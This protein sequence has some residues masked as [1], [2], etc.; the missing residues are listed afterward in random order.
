MV[1]V[2]RMRCSSRSLNFVIGH[3]VDIL[4]REVLFYRFLFNFI[5][6]FVAFTIL[7]GS[8]GLDIGFK[9]NLVL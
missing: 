1:K 4:N 3:S 6:G 2:K 5:S 8:L 7:E 9:F